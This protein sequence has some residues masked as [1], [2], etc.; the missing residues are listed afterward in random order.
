MKQ[1]SLL[2]VS[3]DKNDFYA[4]TPECWECYKT[5]THF[6]NTF[7]DGS[8]DYFLYPRRSPRCCYHLLIKGYGT[9]G[10]DI[11]SKVID[12]VWHSW[13]VLYEPKEMP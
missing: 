3:K 7:P 2:D 4:L 12:N 8:K 11:K 1:L 5:C 9:S 10:K 6:T 13:C